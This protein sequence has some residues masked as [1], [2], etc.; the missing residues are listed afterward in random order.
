[1]RSRNTTAVAD[2]LLTLA[3]CASG[4]G[5]TSPQKMVNETT[6]AAYNDDLNAMQSH[7]DGE[8]AKQVTLDGVNT[9]S[10]KLKAFGAYKGLAH[11]PIPMAGATITPP[12]S[13]RPR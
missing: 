6:Q 1:M 8:L 9:L 2:G 4:D 13:T 12:P 7:F 10:S 11:Q 5:N 3:L